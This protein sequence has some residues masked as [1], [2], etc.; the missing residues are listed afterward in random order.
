MKRRFNI[1]VRVINKRFKVNLKKLFLGHFIDFIDKQFHINVL[2]F[3]YSDDFKVCRY[4]LEGFI[5]F[6]IE[7]N[8]S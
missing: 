3:V 8:I 6:N 2:I 4:L 5:L 7:K 1:I